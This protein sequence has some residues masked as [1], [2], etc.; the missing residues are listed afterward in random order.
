MRTPL[1]LLAA[2]ATMLLA[3][4]PAQAS[5]ALA[6]TQG[7]VLLAFDTASP[8]TIDRSLG[9]FGLGPGETLRGVDVRLADGQ[10][11]GISVP[12][13]SSANSILRTYRIDAQSGRATFVGAAP[14]PLA[15][16]G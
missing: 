10:L 12:S 9:V 3:A 2:A 8:G 4:V 11:Y 6:L 7:N 15:G 5:P 14:A 13:G 1:V 16:A